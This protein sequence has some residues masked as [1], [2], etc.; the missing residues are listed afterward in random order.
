MRPLLKTVAVGALALSFSGVPVIA[1][2]HPDAQEH[3][4][5]DHHDQYVRHDDWKKGEH[6]RHEDWDRGTRV[7]DWQA[8]H[9]HRPQKGYEWREIDGQYVMANPDGV[10][11][12]VVVPH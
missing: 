11:F 6:L 7:E 9:L 10:I 4:D 3:H 8:R 12:E 1:Q 5:Q 2:E